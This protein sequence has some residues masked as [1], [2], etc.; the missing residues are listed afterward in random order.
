M[1]INKMNTEPETPD[2]QCPRCY[3]MN[4]DSIAS[5]SK[6]GQEHPAET[7]YC[8]ARRNETEAAARLA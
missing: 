1:K 7:A 6:C 2:W 3:E 8:E 5:C 4:D